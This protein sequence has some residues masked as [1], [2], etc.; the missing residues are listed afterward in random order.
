MSLDSPGSDVQVISKAWG[1]EWIF[2]AHPLYAGKLLRVLPRRQSSLHRHVVKDETFL[3]LAGELRVQLG[4]TARGFLRL[5]PGDALRVPQGSW[6]RFGNADRNSMTIVVEASTADN[7][8]DNER[9][10]LSGDYCESDWE[11]SS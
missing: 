1:E 7:S 3:V 8:A 10:T 5:V 4:A 9:L 11:G 6:H 2:A